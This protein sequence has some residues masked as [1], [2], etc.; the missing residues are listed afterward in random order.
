MKGRFIAPALGKIVEQKFARKFLARQLDGRVY[1]A[2][3]E[4]DSGNLR[5]IQEKKYEFVSAALSCVVKNL[6][7][8][9][10][11]R[12]VMKKIIQV[13]VE[14]CFLGGDES[15]Q[16]AIK[17]FDE[18]YGAGPPTFIVLSPTQRCN[19]HCTG[20]YA[21]S[22][23]RTATTLPYP[24]VDRIVGEVHDTFGSRFVTI[25]GG[26]PFLYR[27]EGKTLLDIFEKYSDM[28]FLIYTN[29]TLITPEIAQ[30]LGELGNATP[31]ISVEGFE[32]DTDRRRGQG[33]YQ[34]IL[35]AFGDLRKAGVPFGISVTA[36]RQNVDLLL[37]D[38]FYDFYFEEQGVTYMW[39][40]QLMPI[41]R[42]QDLLDLMVTPEERV[43]LYRMW[44][45]ML[46]GKKYCLAD[47]WNSGVLSNGCIAYGRSGG[48]IHVDWNG[49]VMPCVFIPYS[50]DNIHDLY[51]NGK[52]L[53]DALFSD[54]MK[55]GRNWQEEYGLSNR[56]KPMNWL[57][58]CSIRDHYEHFRKSVLP[59]DA[60]PENRSAAE[61]LRS[62][63]YYDTLRRYDVELERL[64]AGIWADEYLG[65]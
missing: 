60:K 5:H 17:R 11:S 43:K 57:M 49:D 4:K 38:E 1:E 3:V 27:S 62:D 31:A 35:R 47:F 10:V 13:L 61:S 46:K 2:I 44:E 15:R 50:V 65:R 52:T 21:S 36:T 34:E 26:E 12:H 56:R 33:T 28:F 37:T 29:G 16:A 6:D 42:G 48:Y 18:R 30:R 64:T 7:R 39:Q 8:G 59:E 54:F 32:E 45:R 40:F 25:S 58:P 19:L 20:C 23:S 22:T 14:N 63:Q 53:A 9:C 41:G 24:E 55:N 51:G